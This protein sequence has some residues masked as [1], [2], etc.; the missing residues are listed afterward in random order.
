MKTGELVN[1]GFPSRLLFPIEKLRER[2]ELL[3]RYFGRSLSGSQPI[4]D[5]RYIY[6]TNIHAS[7]LSEVIER[8]RGCLVYCASMHAT[9]FCVHA[10]GIAPTEEL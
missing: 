2:A 5:V 9:L 10:T 8:H 7:S 3:L 6:R 1:N 4:T